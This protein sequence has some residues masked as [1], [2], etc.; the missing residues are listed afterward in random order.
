MQHHPITKHFTTQEVLGKNFIID[1]RDKISNAYADAGINMVFTGHSHASD[2]AKVS[3]NSR[4]VYDVMTSAIIGYPVTTRTVNLNVAN[5]DQGRNLNFETNVHFYSEIDYI[6]ETTGSNIKDIQTYAYDR[7]MTPESTMTT[8]SNKTV[9]NALESIKSKGGTKGILAN[10]L[11]VDSSQVT[12]E[13]ARIIVDKLPKTV[14]D[15]I[16]L[17]LSKFKF[18]VYYN[19]ELNSI[20]IKQETK[21]FDKLA[22]EVFIPIEELKL[23]IEDMYADIDNNILNNPDE[24]CAVFQDIANEANNYKL[25]GKYSAIDVYLYIYKYYKLGQE[26]PDELLEDY[27]NGFLKSDKSTK[28]I[29]RNVIYKSSKKKMVKLLSKNELHL[30][31][32]LKVGNNSITSKAVVKVITSSFDDMSDIWTKVVKRVLYS[33]KVLTIMNDFCKEIITGMV[34]DENV[35]EDN[36]ANI[37][38]SLPN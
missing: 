19:E 27:A 18:K 1:D 11:K 20:S 13:V 28:K 29:L 38:I 22:I 34:K 33:D 5:N 31:K 23:L 2:I 21:R 25:N 12:N 6:D 9:E 37:I 16:E 24:V 4:D 14:E 35:T 36:N 32:V 8:L 26:S 10:M 30:D 17:K 7:L 3:H 15:G